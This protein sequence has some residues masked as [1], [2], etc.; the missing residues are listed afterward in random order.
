MIRILSEHNIVGRALCFQNLQ[1]NPCLLKEVFKIE[2]NN[3]LFFFGRKLI[4]RFHIQ[5][6]FFEIIL[7]SVGEGFL[8]EVRNVTCLKGAEQKRLISGLDKYSTTIFHRELFCRTHSESWESPL[9]LPVC[10]FY[11]Q[12]FCIITEQMYNTLAW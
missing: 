11:T 3:R 4:L 10:P 6:T 12:I 8:L 7:N 5:R 2:I 9:H 1:N